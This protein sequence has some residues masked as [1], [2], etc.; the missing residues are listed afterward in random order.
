MST[1]DS[2]FNLGYMDKDVE[3]TGYYSPELLALANAE[4]RCLPGAGFAI[5]TSAAYNAYEAGH[6]TITRVYADVCH[7]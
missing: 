2:H 6:P 4:D 5:R 1:N 7:L 3:I